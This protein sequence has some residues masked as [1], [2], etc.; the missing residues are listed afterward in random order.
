MRKNVVECWM[1]ARPDNS[2]LSNLQNSLN[3]KFKKKKKKKI[4]AS[5]INLLVFFL[6]PSE[7]FIMIL[8]SDLF[9]FPVSFCH[10]F[11]ILSLPRRPLKKKKKLFFPFFLWN[12]SCVLSCRLPFFSSSLLFSCPKK[13]GS[14]LNK[15]KENLKN[16]QTFLLCLFFC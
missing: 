3:S 7:R 16:F 9:V 13:C 6:I 10:K 8:L 5:R 15:K 14:T 11:S 4:Q 1:C 2:T 12:V